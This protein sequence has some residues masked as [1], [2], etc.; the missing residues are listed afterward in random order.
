[1]GGWDPFN[2][3][4]DTDLGMRLARFGYRIGVIASTT[5]EEAPAAFG[6]WLHQRTRWFK[7]WIQTFF[8]H[9]RAPRRLLAELGVKG[10]LALPAR[11]GA[12]LTG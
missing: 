11:R 7:G 6:P 1:M 3:T 9:M 12:G 4:E 5:D 2:V 10:F 8:V